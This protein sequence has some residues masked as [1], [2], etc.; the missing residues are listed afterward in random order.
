[1]SA[2]EL[3]KALKA[4]AE[5]VEVTQE[6]KQRD[7][8]LIPHPFPDANPAAEQVVLL[9]PVGEAA[10]LLHALHATGE[11]VNRLLAER[12]IVLDNQALDAA[13]PPGVQAVRWRFK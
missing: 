6:L 7:M 1:M 11:D 3:S 4:P 12:A 5:L 13:T 2:A 10:E 8:P 9:D